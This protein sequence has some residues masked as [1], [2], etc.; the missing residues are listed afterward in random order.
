MRRFFI[1][2]INEKFHCFNSKIV[3]IVLITNQFKAMGLSSFFSNLFGSAKET[4]QDLAVEAENTF[5]EV[6]EAA[7]PIIENAAELISDVFDSI[8]EVISENTNADYELVSETVV[9][10]S[11][12]GVTET[13]SEEDK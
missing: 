4:T 5:E 3:N 2:L 6:K 12:D 7:E 13:D 1:P 8:K 11:E 9:D 10:V